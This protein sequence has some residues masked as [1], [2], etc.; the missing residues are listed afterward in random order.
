MTRNSML[1]I[2]SVLVLMILIF[3]GCATNFDKSSKTLNAMGY[4]Y[5]KKGQYDK[6]LAQAL[7]NGG[8]L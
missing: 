6:A 5:Y 1:T 7:E 2:S 8:M 3:S 4:E